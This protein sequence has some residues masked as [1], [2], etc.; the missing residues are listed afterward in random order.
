MSDRIE[1][2]W[3][4]LRRAEDSRARQA[5]LP[6]IQALA[7]S[8]TLEVTDRP[9]LSV[10]DIGAGTGANA[11]W[12]APQLDHAL[13][14]AGASSISQ[15]WRLLDHDQALLDARRVDLA[16]GQYRVSE[17]VGTVADVAALLEESR[18][19]AA[20]VIVT[21]SALLDV[22]TPRDIDVLVTSAVASADAA[23]LA[24]SVTGEIQIDP[25]DADDDMVTDL[26]NAHQQRRLSGDCAAQ[27]AAGPAGWNHAVV[28]FQA[29]GW[30]VQLAATPWLLGHG[31][32]PLTLRWLTERAEAAAQMT[33]DSATATRVRDWLARRLR[34]GE[35]SGLEVQV[36]HMDVLALPPR[37]ISAQMSSPRQ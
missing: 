33:P 32:A 35:R 31:S 5:S 18:G 37:S 30:S 10:L 34:H 29:S 6:L 23:L 25:P 26:F 27:G 4:G 13:S 14:T 3:L 7:N 9:R 2:S 20:G 19:E 15:H 16:R 22:L 28:A 24:M 17:Y 11:Q 12:L 21:C 1:A 8:L 36:D